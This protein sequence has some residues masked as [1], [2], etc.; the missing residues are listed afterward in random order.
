MPVSDQLKNQHLLW[1]AGFG[2][3]IYQLDDL[4]RTSPQKLYKAFQKASSKKPEY[5]Q[6]ADNYLQGLMMGFQEAG[7]QQRLEMSEE[8]KKELRKR[9]REGIRNLNLY[10]INEMVNSDAQLREKMSLFWH[11]HFATSTQKVRDAYLMWLQNETFRRNANGSWI[12]MLNEVTRDPAMLIWLDQTQSR[13]S[14][15]PSKPRWIL[16]GAFLL[17]IHRCS[18]TLIPENTARSARRWRTPCRPAFIADSVSRHAPRT[19]NWGRRWIRREGVS[20]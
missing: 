16:P 12:T 20:C 15:P 4:N 14:M 2:P 8:Q 19:R 5:L 10:W 18:T 9:S 17:S 3:A 1:R 11:G 6:A 7:R 13:K